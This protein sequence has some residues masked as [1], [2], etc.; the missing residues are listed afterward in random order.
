MLTLPGLL[1][2]GTTAEFNALNSILSAS[3]VYVYLFI[4]FPE[5]NVAVL[6]IVL[7]RDA[8]RDQ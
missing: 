5:Q 1:S 2:T 7:D 4:S 6:T 8:Q 3:F